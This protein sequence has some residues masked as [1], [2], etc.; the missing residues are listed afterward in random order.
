MRLVSLNAWGGKA[1]GPL[2][3]FLKEASPKTDVFCFQEVLR[4]TSRVKTRAGF[5]V[6]LYSELER[7]LP[8]FRGHMAVSEKRCIP[9]GPVNFHCDP[10]LAIFVRKSYTVRSHKSFPIGVSRKVVP[11]KRGG[12]K[13]IAQYVTVGLGNKPYVFCNVHGIADWPK[14]DT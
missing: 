2:V 8:N 11:W 6:N 9:T 14:T 5:R 7:R 10:G 13:E 3:K 4:T 1:F 12:W